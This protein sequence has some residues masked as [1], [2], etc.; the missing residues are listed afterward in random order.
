MYGHNK[1]IGIS[2]GNNRTKLHSGGPF[3]KGKYIHSKTAIKNPTKL[4]DTFKVK[5]LNPVDNKKDIE[6]QTKLLTKTLN[7][8]FAELN[9][10][11]KTL[12]PKSEIIVSNLDEIESPSNEVV[13]KNPVKAVSITNFY[14][15]QKEIGKLHK[16]VQSLK[17]DPKII[18]PEIKLPEI[19]IPQSKAEVILDRRETLISDDPKKSVPVRLTDGKK[20][21]E[22]LEELSVRGS[23]SSH[24]FSNSEGVK[25]QALVNEQRNVQVD[26]M[27]ISALAQK[28]TISGSITYIALA[29]P[30]TSQVSAKWQV[31]KIDESDSNNTIITWADG[32]AKFDNKATDLSALTY[33]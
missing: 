13:I 30:G 9:N 11:I 14:E 32:D 27:T 25:Q 26:V 23:G 7:D 29:S 19:V 2:Q 21:Y 6:L 33:S 1:S 8:K 4:P 31:K 20:F 10:L 17:L 18:V 22:A 16:I 5:E 15:I 3:F 28:I 24:V 12:S